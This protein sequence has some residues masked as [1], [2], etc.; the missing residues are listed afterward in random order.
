MGLVIETQKYG[1]R[2]S[3]I[4]TIDREKFMEGEEAGTFR[5]EIR[6]GV[7]DLMSKD[8]NRAYTFMEIDALKIGRGMPA[9]IASSLYVL[10][11]LD[12]LIEEKKVVSRKIGKKTYY[13]MAQK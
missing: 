13:A 3:D 4:M 6:A 5:E 10:L 11:V 12:E 8:S 9:G 7:T 1:L 2:L